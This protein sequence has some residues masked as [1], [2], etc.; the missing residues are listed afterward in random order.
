M[1][2]GGSYR[3]FASGRAA[4]AAIL[5]AL[6]GFA[7]PGSAAGGFW[8]ERFRT[9]GFTAVALNRITAEQLDDFARKNDYWGDPPKC[10]RQLDLYMDRLE[11]RVSNGSIADLPLP[12]TRVIGTM[13]VPQDKP[14]TRIERW[15]DTACSKRGQHEYGTWC[16]DLL[17]A[18]HIMPKD[19]LA[20]RLAGLKAF[21][22]DPASGALPECARAAPAVMAWLQENAMV[23]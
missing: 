3:R 4:R 6:A 16:K 18:L 20:I 9:V 22:D 8:I 19:K 17:S 21:L 5:V 14:D 23:K 7:M 15:L 11:E 12:L 2:M 13:V 10:A 1:P